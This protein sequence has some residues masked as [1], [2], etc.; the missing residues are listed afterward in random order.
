M[1]DDRRATAIDCNGV[2][3]NFA[4]GPDLAR[5]KRDEI[6]TVTQDSDK[7]YEVTLSGGA[8]EQHD[9]YDD[10]A[11]L[12]T[13]INGS[14]RPVIT[15]HQDEPGACRKA[16]GADKQEKVSLSCRMDLRLAKP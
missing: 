16:P 11:V 2:I 1:R 3:I 12:T 4:H 10:I 5:D 13:T 9:F 15:H 6:G 14:A 8:T 7:H